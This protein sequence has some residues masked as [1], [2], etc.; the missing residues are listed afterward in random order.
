MSL[1]KLENYCMR[2]DHLRNSMNDEI[3]TLMHQCEKLSNAFEIVESGKYKMYETEK[4][5]HFCDLTLARL[6]DFECLATKVKVGIDTLILINNRIKT[7]AD[8][9]GLAEILQVE[10]NDYFLNCISETLKVEEQNQEF[11][12]KLLQIQKELA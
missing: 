4:Q 8:K 5:K 11:K 12:E 9:F 6:K 3:M 1:Q 10:L 7:M 2:F